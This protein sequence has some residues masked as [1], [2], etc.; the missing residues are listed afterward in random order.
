MV[1]Q[2]QYL[3]RNEFAL[4]CHNCWHSHEKCTSTSTLSVGFYYTGQNAS[5][6]RQTLADA[7]LEIVVKSEQNLARAAISET[8][9]SDFSYE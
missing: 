4:F 1:S 3:L 6:V 7:L 8:H 2:W 9:L 5:V